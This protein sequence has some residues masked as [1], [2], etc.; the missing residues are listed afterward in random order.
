MASSVVGYM[1]TVIFITNRLRSSIWFLFL[2]CIS[3]FLL[4][5][6]FF[7]SNYDDVVCGSCEKFYANGFNE[8]HVSSFAA[9]SLK[10]VSNIYFDFITI[11]LSMDG[12]RFVIFFLLF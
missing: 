7:R 4:L 12:N 10:L 8:L 9:I 5:V 11:P 6:S 3:F 1:K 2:Y